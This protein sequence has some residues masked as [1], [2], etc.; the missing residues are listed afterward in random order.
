MSTQ[1]TSMSL[2][3]AN[4]VLIRLVRQLPRVLQKACA[5]S[6][7]LCNKQ[8]LSVLRNPAG[9]VG[10]ISKQVQFPDGKS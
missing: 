3:A 10:Q 7:T 9:Q 4:E 6:D 5:D 1:Q 2:L 8:L